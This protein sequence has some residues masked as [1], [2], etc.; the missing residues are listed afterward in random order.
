VV[1][2]NISSIEF[3]GGKTKTVQKKTKVRSRVTANELAEH[4]KS[5]S[6]VLIMG[7]KFADNDSIGA[8]VGIARFAK[9]ILAQSR[10]PEN[11]GI[12]GSSVNVNVDVDVNIIV[13]IHDANIKSAFN[14]LRGHDEYKDVFIDESAAL[15]K[16]TA[17]TLAVAI[18]VN[19]PLHFESEAVFKN[20]HKTAVI[21]HHRKTVEFE[22]EPDI[23][24]LEPSASSASELVAEILEQSFAPGELLKEEAELLLA[25]IYLDTKNF[26]K[27]TGTR[28]FAA[29]VYLRGEGATPSDSLALFKTNVEEFTKEAKFASNTILYRHMIAISIYEEEASISDKT[30]GAKAADS[31]LTIDGVAASFVIYTVNGE[32]HISARSLGKV[33]VQVIMEAFGGGG[34][35]EGAGAQ[36]KNSSLREVA[37]TLKKTIDEYFDAG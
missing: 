11:D 4:I 23:V 7:H 5:C 17:E 6:N 13:N 18:D 33:N 10:M 20:A 16:I 22:R 28:T 27:N 25:G 12:S 2:K 36:I 3:F 15:D 35:F 32:V 19:N 37:I 9:Y 24:Y 14:K 1:V 31:M 8:C 26:S 30:A 34:H 29:A 21:D